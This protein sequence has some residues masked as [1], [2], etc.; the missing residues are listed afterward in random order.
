MEQ[1][2]MNMIST[3]AFLTEMDASSK[4]LTLA[5]KF[6]AVWEKK[7]AKAARAGGVSLMA[8]SLAA[9]G[10]SSST[11]TTDDTATDD[12]ATETP[13]DTTPVAPA[14]NAIAMDGTEA[15]VAGTSGADNIS[16]ATS[17]LT[18]G[19]T[20][21]TKVDITGGEGADTLTLSM[22]GDFAGFATTGSDTGS[23]TGVETV[24]ITN[25]GSIARTFDATGVSGV[26]TYVI[27]GT[28]GAIILKDVADL[29]AVELSN[30][31]SGAMKMDFVAAGAVVT[32]TS[33]ALSLSVSGVGSSTANID[34]DI[35]SIE[36]LNITSNVASTAA[37]TTNY[38]NLT[39]ADS[40]TSVTIAGA[41]DTKVSAAP[42]T[43]TSF[44]AGDA[45][46][47]ITATLS[48][49]AAG[50]LTT[51]K[52]GAGA[53]TVTVD[54]ADLT[55]NATVAMGDG[56]D[57]LALTGSTASTTQLVMTG[58]ETVEITDHTATST[59]SLANTSG[60]TTVVA[61]DNAAVFSGN[62]TMIGGTGSLNLDVTGAA[63][64]TLSNDTSGAVD[65]DF[66]ADDDATTASTN[67]SAGT[68]TF[69]NTTSVDIDVANLVDLT[70]NVVAAKATSA[71]INIGTT[72]QSDLNIDLAKAQ[73][74]DITAKGIAAFADGS[75]DESDFSK[76]QTM[77]LNTTK[78]S[79]FQNLVSMADLTVSGSA[80][81]AQ[82]TAGTI[83]ATT[84]SN[85]LKVTIDGI[86]ADFATTAIDAG[87]GS[88][89][90]DASKNTGDMS[91]GTLDAAGTVSVT[92]GALGTLTTGQITAG[93]AVIDASALISTATLSTGANGTSYGTT[94]IT[95]SSTTIKGSSIT[96]TSADIAAAATTT[97]MV[98]DVTGGLAAD[99]FSVQSAAKTSSITVKGDLGL[100]ADKVF[101]EVAD[102]T[103]NTT[104]TVTVDVSGLTADT[105]N[106][107][108]VVIDLDNEA[109]NSI[110]VT[111]SA[112]T[113]DVVQF[114]SATT[115]FNAGGKTLTMS[116]I[117]TLLLADDSSIAAS[118]VSGLTIKIDGSAASKTA[119]FNGTGVADTIDMSGLSQGGTNTITLKYDGGAG[120]DT[121]T[122]SA[123]A[124][125]ILGGD[126]ADTI[127][128]GDKIDLI[129]GGAGSDTIYLSE[130]TATSTDGDAND[131]IYV[132]T[133]ATTFTAEAG[134]TIYGFVSGTDDIQFETEVVTATTNATGAT[135]TAGA[136]L[137]TTNIAI[138]TSD[139]TSGDGTI[140]SATD[141][142]AFV[143]D[144]ASTT[145]ANVDVIFVVDDG[146]DSYIWWYDGTTDNV[147][148]DADE[149]TL[150]ATLKGED[151]VA[152]GDFIVA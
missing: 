28:N 147:T 60:L 96:A 114:G 18:S 141:V 138:V 16:A 146:T 103:T 134:D 97:A 47:A 142:A 115:A 132:G 86:K 48:N 51:V 63:T 61:G 41:A 64:G 121:I 3:G 90:I 82:F 144:F 102:F 104:G 58:V 125:T 1:K 62:V 10:G 54:L 70:G 73:T 53:D 124:D 81:T 118:S 7:N 8:L 46:G 117:E 140:T 40:A 88:L 133:N 29:A 20:L 106:Q 110:T 9:C 32:G 74:V 116:G 6:A 22:N 83:G 80:S 111:G 79:T 143:A 43:I 34:V 68:L 113:A 31:A 15:T 130:K 123:G 128:G 65:I 75:N 26:E 119:T 108:A 152:A 37:G 50:K 24:S 19:T 21:G 99:L 59:M 135:Q 44:D 69:A 112:G 139:F 93:T 129:T 151:Q 71:T 95:A 12:T 89:T 38:L 66:I 137:T 14:V 57:K 145:A 100:G 136:A 2:N 27:D 56:A 77:T 72:E 36:T 101:V 109:T 5:E 149:V 85:D 39:N 150:I 92:T 127:V 45:T 13:V 91:L 23:M 107:N 30:Q 94:D 17:T 33:D 98:V 55:A 35:S 4:Q 49:A 52:T 25:A 84:L 11:T 87:S 120:A 67:A 105:T 42:T 131:V 76:V 148:V 122:G 126:G 78:L